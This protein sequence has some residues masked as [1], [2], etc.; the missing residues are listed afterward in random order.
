MK[1]SVISSKNIADII[2]TH[3]SKQHNALSEDTTVTFVITVQT[4]TF[5]TD[6]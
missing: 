2:K 4:E 1:E 3:A 6:A 5:A